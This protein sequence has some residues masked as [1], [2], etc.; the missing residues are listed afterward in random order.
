MDFW[1]DAGKNFQRNRRLRGLIKILPGH[2]FSV[3]RSVMKRFYIT[4]AIDYANGSPHIGHAYEKIFADAIARWHRG[5]GEECHFL[6]GLDEHGQ[7]VEQ[8]AKKLELT[9]QTVCDRAATEWQSLCRTLDLSNDDYIRTTEGRHGEIVRKILQNLYDKKEIYFSEYVGFYSQQS[10]QFVQEKDRIDGQ[11]PAHFGDVSEIHETNYFFRLSKYQDWL[12]DFLQ[13][14]PDFILPNFRQRQ[15]LEFLKSPLNDLCISRPKSRLEW[16]IE[17]PF[18]RNYVTY[19]WFDALINYISAVGFGHDSFSDFWPADFHVIGKDILAP[20]H[21]IYWPI[22][23]HVLE[24]PMP[25]HLLVHGWWLTK[26]GEKMSK[27][28]G[29]TIA[30]LD[31][32]KVYGIDAFRYF[33]LREMPLG[34]DSTFSAELF[35]ARYNGELANDLGNL[36]N[37]VLNMLDRYCKGRIPAISL[38]EAPEEKLSNLANETFAQV[39]QFYGQADFNHGLETLFSFVREINRYAEIRAPWRLAKSQEKIDRLRLETALATMAAGLASVAKFLE[40]IMV[41]TADRILQSL[42]L[43]SAVKAI[44]PGQDFTG[45]GQRW[46]TALA[47][48]CIQKCDILFPRI[49]DKP[50]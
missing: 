38:I 16:G 32:I 6:T 28:L 33:L 13:K 11:W 4:T 2:R 18:D 24:L 44:K 47:G 30:P 42:G 8:T 36:F 12:I 20:A 9:P 26:G 27:S 23:L 5:L 37:R 14:N 46:Q 35:L 39:T 3:S 41:R 25:K 45:A 10:E 7:K 48:K 1:P 15:V 21:A 34:Q 40:P 43:A 50:Q 31:Y 22:M 29:N 17:L 49:E 19:V